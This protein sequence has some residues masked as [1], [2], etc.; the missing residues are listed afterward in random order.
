MLYAPWREEFILGPKPDGCI[1]C[2]PQNQPGVRELI[3]HEDRR[4]FV[5]LNRYPYNSGHLMVIPYRHVAMLEDLQVEERNDLMELVSVASRIINEEIKPAGLNIGMNLG[6]A[7]GAGV[8]GHLHV[9]L[10]PRWIGDNNFMPVLSD[11]RV[12]SV[13]LDSM[14]AKLRPAFR[15]VRPNADTDKPVSN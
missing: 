15:R 5:V 4:V 1:F 12:T 3:L 2:D 7:G 11:T 14:L 13:G 10:V 8:E 9:H 6:R